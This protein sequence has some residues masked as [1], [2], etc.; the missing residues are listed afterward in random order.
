MV[1]EVGIA[2]TW[3]T[4]ASLIFNAEDFSLW[5]KSP[6]KGAVFEGLV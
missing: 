4:Y 1:L 5:K 2:P 6:E 3:L